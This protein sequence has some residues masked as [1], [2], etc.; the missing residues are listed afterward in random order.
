MAD[1]APR[2]TPKSTRGNTPKS[3]GGNTPNASA[4][5]L[6]RLTTGSPATTPPGSDTLPRAIHRK[7]RGNGLVPRNATAPAPQPSDTVIVA[8][9]QL[10]S[11]ATTPGG[12]RHDKKHGTLGRITA[13]REA[14]A[15]V[16][17]SLKNFFAVDKLSVDELE[18]QA[19]EKA[20]TQEGA[21]ME[22][23]DDRLTDYEYYDYASAS[24]A[25]VDATMLA[26]EDYHYYSSEKDEEVGD[27]NF[28]YS[29]HK[30]STAVSTVAA[31]SSLKASPYRMRKSTS[32][33]RVSVLAVS[34]AQAF[35]AAEHRAGPT[36]AT[37]A[38]VAPFISSGPAQNRDLIK[39]LE[40]RVHLRAAAILLSD[41]DAS[42]N[43]GDGPHR[44]LTRSP[45]RSGAYLQKRKSQ[46][47]APETVSS[48]N[49]K[50]QSISGV[51]SQLPGAI[52]IQVEAAESASSSASS[53]P[54]PLA[55]AAAAAKDT[56][57]GTA[58]PSHVSTTP[59]TTSPI[60]TSPIATSLLADAQTLVNEAQIPPAIDT[61]PALAT[62][63]TLGRVRN[64]V[65]FFESIPTTP[66]SPTKARSQMDSEIRVKRLMLRP[67]SS[68]MRIPTVNESSAS[69]LASSPPPL[70]GSSLQVLA[71][72]KAAAASD[73]DVADVNQQ[74]SAYTRSSRGLWRRPVR[75]AVAP[76][77][78]LTMLKEMETLAATSRPASI[79][80]DASIGKAD[81]AGETD[82]SDA[83]KQGLPLLRAERRQSIGAAVKKRG[84]RKGLGLRRPSIADP[85]LVAEHAELGSP[86]GEGTSPP[87][88]PPSKTFP[89][90]KLLP[91]KI[92]RSRDNFSASS[93]HSTP[94]P[95]KL[96]RASK[97]SPSP[98]PL[99]LQR[100]SSTAASSLKQE[101]RDSRD[102]FLDESGDNLGYNSKS[103]E[104]SKSKDDMKHT[105]GS[106]PG[107]SES[108][109]PKLRKP[110]PG[111][112][113]VA[114][115]GRQRRQSVLQTL[116]PAV[117]EQLVRMQ[118]KVN[119]ITL[120]R[121]ILQGF[122]FAI[123]IHCAYYA[124]S[125]PNHV[126]RKR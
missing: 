36:T 126:L 32:L 112:L 18:A 74:T 20:A 13:L 28:A 92:S 95:D 31:L 11:T 40:E 72:E 49:A 16:G 122:Q 12:D 89:S 110:S 53:T 71:R 59:V 63:S 105:T 65:Q 125:V 3:T 34:A 39:A 5:S 86:Q 116:S 2:D 106:K 87:Q 17:G 85:D 8:E 80:K 48:V 73:N 118:L 104:N 14:T 52:A 1:G 60:A 121:R 114:K 103:D 108:T 115:G 123:Y 55:V 99:R 21:V 9:E 7:S 15:A 79:A 69:E 119:L 66:R 76:A 37:T 97:A 111:D 98:K 4:R 43:E 47:P 29:P 91:D 51:P 45:S 93:L 6:P 94:R 25:D 33:M 38:P 10:P 81:A 23:A 90:S 77:T 120:G 84:G 100:R 68:R 42:G 64:A 124:C 101:P 50:R 96:R 82:I 61:S 70:R 44:T 46:Q 41:S 113:I 62:L 26:L 19:M 56:S 22:D 30:T 117:R 75:N 78:R 35:S 109:K 102:D 83:T 107:L 88:S 57:S 24:D 27:M 58:A 54:S 67:S